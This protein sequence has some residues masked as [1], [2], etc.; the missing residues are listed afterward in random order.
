MN[1][2][3]RILINYID[4]LVLNYNENANINDGYSLNFDRLNEHEMSNLTRLYIEYNDRNTSECFTYSD[5]SYQDDD[6][7]CALIE[8]LKNPTY[9]NKE[10]LSDLIL[11]RSIEIHKKEIQAL[12]DER[13]GHLFEEEMG[14]FGLHKGYHNDNGE[15]YWN[16]HA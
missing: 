10:K 11:N 3:Y 6:I 14:N 13:C 7:S 15:I 1:N 8:L 16:S 5:K 9:D 12:I 2:N 4:L